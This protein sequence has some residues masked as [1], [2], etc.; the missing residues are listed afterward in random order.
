MEAANV[1]AQEQISQESFR[2]FNDAYNTARSVLQRCVENASEERCDQYIAALIGLQQLSQ[3]EFQALLREV[4][5]SLIK[6]EM[7]QE[8]FRTF[9]DAYKAAAATKGLSEPI[10]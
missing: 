10:V 8:A 6:K 1:L 7:T 2:T 5:T 3:A 4:E 9:M